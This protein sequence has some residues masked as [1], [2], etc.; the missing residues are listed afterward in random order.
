MTIFGEV[1][2]FSRV[3]GLQSQHPPKDTESFNIT[4]LTVVCLAIGCSSLQMVWYFIID[5]QSFSD[6]A[7]AIVAFI[8]TFSMSAIFATLIWQR[9][10]YFAFFNNLRR[11]I[12]E[13]K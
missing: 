10:Q 13:R 7:E 4:R 11:K 6:R 12:I 8:N 2:R 1:A 9:K 3:I 5:A